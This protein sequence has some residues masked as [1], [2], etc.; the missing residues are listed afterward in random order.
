A[1]SNDGTEVKAF[2]VASGKQLSSF[3]VLE[4]GVVPGASLAAG[5]LD[6]DGKAEIVF[7]GGPT[8]APFSP[9]ANGPDQRVAVYGPDGTLMV[10]FNAYP[11]VF[12]GGVRVAFGNVGSDGK[13][14]IVT[15]PGP[16]IAPEV[17]V[18]AQD[19]LAPRDR[20]TRLA[21]FLAYEPAFRGGVS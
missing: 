4:P 1:E 10:G 18:Y 21:H 15:A 3:F 2:D 12:Q 13:N 9:F 5:D 16:G 8:A 17:D 7:G 14:D 20:G 6:G 19:W 11:G